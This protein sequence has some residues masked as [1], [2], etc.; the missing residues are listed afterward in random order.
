MLKINKMQP[1][2]TP[3]ELNR[4][5]K[6][7]TPPVCD[8]M[9]ALGIE[10]RFFMKA[11]VKP[12]T[13]CKKVIGVAYTVLA[14]DGN[15]FPVHYAVYQGQPGYVLVVDTNE[16]EDGPYMGELMVSTAQHMGISGIIVDG[17]VRDAELISAM[18]YPIFAR[19][20]IPNQPGKEQLG[21]IN[22]TITCAGVEVNAGDVILGD[23]DGVVVIPRDRLTEVLAAAENKEAVDLARRDAIEQFFDGNAGNIACKDVKELMSKEVLR[24]SECMRED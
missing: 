6:L 5:E 8:A 17:Y 4:L 15:S 18:D 1:P 13:N 19:G 10:K 3:T 14:T 9:A 2:L 23:L 21:E 7:S 11:A 12:L 20:F 22:G 16:F 24:L